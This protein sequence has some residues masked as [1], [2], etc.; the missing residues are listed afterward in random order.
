MIDKIKPGSFHFQ[1]IE[2][3]ENSFVN[4]IDFCEKKYNI[5]RIITWGYMSRLNSYE[6]LIIYIVTLL[7]LIDGEQIS[8][9]DMNTVQ[10][11]LTP[12]TA[13]KT[14]NSKNHENA[15]REIDSVLSN[16][17]SE[18]AKPTDKF[19]DEFSAF[20]YGE[21]LFGGNVNEYM[22]VFLRISAGIRSIPDDLK[23]TLR[24]TRVL[25]WRRNHSKST[26]KEQIKVRNSIADKKLIEYSVNQVGKDTFRIKYCSRVPGKYFLTINVN[27]IPVVNNPFGIII[28]PNETSIRG[29]G[30]EGMLL[31]EKNDIE[32]EVS[33]LLDTGINFGGFKEDI[34]IK[35]ISPSS[36]KIA[37]EI[38]DLKDGCYNVTYVPGSFGKFSVKVKIWSFLVDE[39]KSPMFAMTRFN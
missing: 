9:V 34:D 14:E 8:P 26:E 1:N 35:I 12:V 24:A 3:E 37:C 29:E 23:I 30:V 38:S 4:A 7:K 25:N 17:I 10:G 21:G 32:R 20:A 16:S 6:S 19:S 39:K 33:F 31:E 27:D 15:A 5:P 2:L 36:E 28:M 13:E 11:N 18:V 22:L